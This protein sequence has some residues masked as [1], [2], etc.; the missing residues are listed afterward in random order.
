MVI[1]N[2]IKS[3]TECSGDTVYG[4]MASDIASL[5][6][7][8]QEV[9]RTGKKNNLLGGKALIQ[10]EETKFGTV[11]EMSKHFLN[12]SVRLEPLLKGAGLSTY[13][14]LL[15][16]PT[17]MSIDPFHFFPGSYLGVLQPNTT[18]TNMS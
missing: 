9:K 7:G 12:F 17:L 10:G 1:K 11:F 2:V 13:N 15:A 4:A 16:R 18:R 6:R 5:K 14:F 8:V 3:V